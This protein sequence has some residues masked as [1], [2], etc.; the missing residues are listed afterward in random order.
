MIDVLK[1]KCDLNSTTRMKIISLGKI[2][3]IQLL[4]SYIQNGKKIYT[5]KNLLENNLTPLELYNEILYNFSILVFNLRKEMPNEMK[6]LMNI[7]DNNSFVKYLIDLY[8]NEA[9]FRETLELT[10]CF[11]LYILIKIYEH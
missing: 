6:Y 10:V 2:K 5:M 11:N 1:I 3:F 8:I 7:A 4:I 9:R